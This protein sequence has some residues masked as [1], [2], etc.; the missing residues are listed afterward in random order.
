MT[1]C[2]GE[3]PWQ[4]SSE[5]PLSSSKSSSTRIALA[6]RMIGSTLSSKPSA[7]MFSRLPFSLA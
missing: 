5:S 2:P 7:C 1:T 4:G 6:A 3:W